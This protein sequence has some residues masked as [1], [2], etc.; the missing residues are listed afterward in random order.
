MP[1]A[2]RIAFLNWADANQSWIIED[3]YDSEYRYAGRPIPALASL[4]KAGRSLYI[5]SFSKVFSDA[6]RLGYLVIPEPLI[7]RFTETLRRFGVK[8]SIAA[9][10]TLGA[11]I[12]DEDF[13]RHIRRTRR[14]YGERR[15]VF[16]RL[17][18]E[19]LGHAATFTDHQA[20][21]QIAVTLPGVAD[22][23]ALAADAS[24]VGVGCL[25]LSGFSA[26]EGGV[27]GLLLGFCAFSPEEMEVA[28]DRLAG[29]IAA[30]RT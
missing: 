19:K 6:L 5:G 1:T 7:E 2:Q 4:D 9:Q 24:A 20:G 13:Y 16:L 23:V 3:D 14:I 29:V 12:E 18:E 15:A 30:R 17:I 21:M 10:R 25:P 26:G 27:S 28:L 22:D 8:A 11:F